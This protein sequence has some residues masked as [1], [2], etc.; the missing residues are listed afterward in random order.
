[1]NPHPMSYSPITCVWTCVYCGHRGVF[2]QRPVFG[3]EKYVLRDTSM[4]FPCYRKMYAAAMARW[5]SGNLALADG[6]GVV[7][8]PGR[9]A[10]ADDVD[11]LIDDP[12]RNILKLAIAVAHIVVARAVVDTL[13]LTFDLGGVPQ[14][15]IVGAP[16]PYSFVRD[17]AAVVATDFAPLQRKARG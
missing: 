2:H 5:S 15:V 6:A 7:T 9:A 8:A 11:G 14:V 10:L 4:C 16:L 12:E 1:M 17:L 3:D 13:E